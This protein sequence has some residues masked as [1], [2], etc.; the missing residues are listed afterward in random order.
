MF[1]F[2]FILFLKKGKKINEKLSGF[3]VLEWRHG[4]GGHLI[5]Q[6]ED[7]TTKSTGTRKKLNTLAHYGIKDSAIMSLIPRQQETYCTQ[8]YRKNKFFFF[9]LTSSHHHASGIRK[10]NYCFIFRF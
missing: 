2:S 8:S 9:S 1:T 7:L 3:F 5:L 10:N 6:D 4:R